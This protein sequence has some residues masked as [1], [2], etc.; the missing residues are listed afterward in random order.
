MSKFLLL[1]T[2]P[3]FLL[4][5]HMCLLPVIVVILFFRVCKKSLKFLWKSLPREIMRFRAFLRYIPLLSLNEWA[6][7]QVVRKLDY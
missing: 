5:F 2:R 1:E 7:G 6:S 4:Q 3:S